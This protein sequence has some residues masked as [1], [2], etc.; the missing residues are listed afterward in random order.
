MF[1]FS[2]VGEP[3][4]VLCD[5]RVEF[6]GNGFAHSSCLLWSEAGQLLT[7]ASH[8]TTIVLLD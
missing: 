5:N 3:T 1:G 4:L 8:S 7:T 6:L 2:G